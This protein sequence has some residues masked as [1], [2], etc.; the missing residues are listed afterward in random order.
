MEGIP[1][2]SFVGTVLDAI[3]V[4]R[5]LGIQFIWIDALCI[6]Q[7]DPKDFTLESVRMHKVYGHAILT[8]SICSSKSAAESFLIRREAETLRL[9][10]CF[11]VKNKLSLVEKTLED[12]RARS[13][14]TKRAWTFQEELLSPRI[15]YWSDQGIFWNCSRRQCVENSSEDHQPRSNYNKH[16]NDMI[17][18]YCEREISNENDRLT[19]LSGIASKFIPE[20]RNTYNG[21]FATS[22]NSAVD[23]YVAGLWQST[24]PES[25]L[26]TVHG[27]PKPSKVANT[28]F[29]VSYVAP[30]WSCKLIKTSDTC[31]GNL[32]S[33]QYLSYKYSR[34]Q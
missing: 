23:E 5:R 8:L 16:W 27:I 34:K 17:E 9:L 7:D 20:P 14:L 1:M 2:K 30:T 28:R 6:I 29:I 21:Y 12:V 33:L 24:L 26:W 22:K 32:I 18:A 3:N 31:S 19:A 4:S 11:L 13:P 25:L 10:S 15:L